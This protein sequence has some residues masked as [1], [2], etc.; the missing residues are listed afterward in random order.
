MRAPEAASSQTDSG[1]VRWNVTRVGG[2]AV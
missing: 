2:R 1:R